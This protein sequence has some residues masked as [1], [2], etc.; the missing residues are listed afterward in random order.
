MLDNDG[1]AARAHRPLAPIT[2][3]EVIAAF[4][5]ASVPLTE[6]VEPMALDELTV[7]EDRATYFGRLQTQPNL[8]LAYKQQLPNLYQL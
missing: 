1:R 4:W 8:P 6:L 3:A 5:A 2:T 7:A